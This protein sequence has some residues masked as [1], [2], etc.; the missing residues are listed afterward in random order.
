M[1][2][3]LTYFLT[4]DLSRVRTHSIRDADISSRHRTYPVVIMR[5]G[6]SAL[7]TD[8]AVLAEDLA[9]HGYVGVGFDAPYR[10]SV[11][12]FPDGSVIKTADQNNAELVHEP[13][14]TRRATKLVRAWSADASFALDQLERLNASDPSGRLRGRLDMRPVGVFGHSLGGATALQFCHDDFRC[15]A[16]IDIDGA[17]FGTVIKE[18]LRQPFMFLLSDHARMPDPADRQ[19]L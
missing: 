9:S 1:G 15:K 8:Y 18:G 14:L 17:P 11:V 19:I 13:E 7:V 10:T 2:V 5:G 16:G 6:H 12:V 4:R 3:L